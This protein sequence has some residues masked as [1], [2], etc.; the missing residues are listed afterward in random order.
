MLPWLQPCYPGYNPVTLLTWLQPCYHGYNP[1][2]VVTTL[3]PWLQPCYHCYNRVNPVTGSGITLITLVQGSLVAPPQG[4]QPVGMH[5]VWSARLRNFRLVTPRTYTG[6]WRIIDS[7]VKQFSG[8]VQVSSD[9]PVLLPLYTWLGY[10]FRPR[11][12]FKTIKNYW[13]HG[14]FCLLVHA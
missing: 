12:C 10:W 4:Q 5:D 8:G 3:L 2:T 11:F 6:T 7:D 9:I 14:F 13:K 1:V